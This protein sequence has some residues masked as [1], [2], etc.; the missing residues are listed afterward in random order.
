MERSRF[1]GTLFTFFLVTVTASVDASYIAYNMD[2]QVSRNSHSHPV[3][4]E[5]HPGAGH[6][7]R[8]GGG[9]LELAF[10]VSNGVLG[11]VLLR[12]ANH[13]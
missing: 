12:R 4:S 9:L 6:A 7:N 13:G 10:V 2:H 1:S 8:S 11:Y 3:T 5:T